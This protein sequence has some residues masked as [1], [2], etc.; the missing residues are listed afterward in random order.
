[1]RYYITTQLR[2]YVATTSA[3]NMVQ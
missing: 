1:M 2:I 3:K